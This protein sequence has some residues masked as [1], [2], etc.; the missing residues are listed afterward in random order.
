MV[1]ERG[2]VVEPVMSPQTAPVFV[3]FVDGQ[4]STRPKWP[5]VRLAIHK[6]EKYYHVL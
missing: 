4:R 5:P 1:A 6:T 2:F 3:P